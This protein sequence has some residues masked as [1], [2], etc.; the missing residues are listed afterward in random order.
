MDICEI[1]KYINAINELY[2]YIIIFFF[3][4]FIKLVQKMKYEEFQNKR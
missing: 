1:I 4:N 2:Y 3:I